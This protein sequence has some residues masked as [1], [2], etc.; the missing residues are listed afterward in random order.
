[1]HLLGSGLEGG[2]FKVQTVLDRLRWLLTIADDPTELTSWSMHQSKSTFIV[3][4]CGWIENQA[5][6][7]FLQQQTRGFFESEIYFSLPTP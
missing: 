4:H 5:V 7:A 1:M 3:V 2:Q 6:E